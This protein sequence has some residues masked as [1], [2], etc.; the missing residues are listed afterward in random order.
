MP[1]RN[2]AA[3]LDPALLAQAWVIGDLFVQK[4]PV[5][6]LVRAFRQAFGSLDFG[7]YAFFVFAI[8]GRGIM[9]NRDVSCCIG[10]TALLCEASKARSISG[11][12]RAMESCHNPH[13]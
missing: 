9:S 8:K 11:G 1:D 2:S 10:I 3:A 7:S 12:V 6:Q 4:D 5:S 13:Q